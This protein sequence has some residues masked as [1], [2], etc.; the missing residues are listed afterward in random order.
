[1]TEAVYGPRR[2]DASSVDA[3][4]GRHA[5]EGEDSLA[6]KA[7][8]ERLLVYRDLVRKTLLRALRL[9]IPRTI[10]RLGARFDDEFSLFLAERGPR[11]HY[12]RDVTPE[13]IEFC[14]P[15]F[16]NGTLGPRYLLDLARHEAL[17]ISVASSPDAPRGSTD[18]LT[19]DARLSFSP[20]LTVA[21][22]SYPV[23]RLPADEDDRSEPV[24]E[25][26]A[27]AVYRDAEHAVRYLE[28]TPLATEILD[29]L[30]GGE[31]L[32]R[33][34][35]R[36]CEAAGVAV[37]PS[38]IEGTSRL[39]ADLAERGA[40]TGV[41]PLSPAGQDSTIAGRSPSEDPR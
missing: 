28:L 31:A 4:L 30:M 39:L 27:L 37:G 40:L 21:R 16:Q 34:V 35:T 19:V 36:A 29:L 8:V 6:M 1:M 26:T 22:Y 33:A 23:H 5:I 11:T 13:F 25:R 32:G 15:R 14:A 10:A 38:V 20:S 2:I 7:S 41:N 12:L 17:E 18:G 9:A 24:A 3:W